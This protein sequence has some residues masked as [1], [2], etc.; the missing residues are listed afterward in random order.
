M[1]SLPFSKQDLS[2]LLDIVQKQP[3]LLC[4]TT[5]TNS[6]FKLTRD[7]SYYHCYIINN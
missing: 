7:T 5:L 6:R 2:S 1:C 4:A 3:K